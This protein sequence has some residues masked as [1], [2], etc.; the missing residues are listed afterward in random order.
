MLSMMS[1]HACDART[2]RFPLTSTKLRNAVES[3]VSMDDQ[4]RSMR[5]SNDE[6][7]CSICISS[8]VIN[9]SE[10]IGVDAPRWALPV[11]DSLMRLYC[12][13]ICTMPASEMRVASM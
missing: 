10:G 6:A 13:T 7:S 8:G 4:T 3:L 9:R 12:S 11:S 5:S 2:P 1:C